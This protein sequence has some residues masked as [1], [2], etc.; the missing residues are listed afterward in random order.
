LPLIAVLIVDALN[1][2]EGEDLALLLALADDADAII[3]RF[4]STPF[5]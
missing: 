4:R 1:A 2:D 3:A 5:N